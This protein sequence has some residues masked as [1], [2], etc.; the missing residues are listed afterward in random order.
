LDLGHPIET[1]HLCKDAEIPIGLITYSYYGN[2]VNQ[3]KSISDVHLEEVPLKRIEGPC[4]DLF[5]EIEDIRTS[6]VRFY[7]LRFYRRFDY[8]NNQIGY[9]ADGEHWRYPVNIEETLKG[10]E[11][12]IS[13]EEDFL[14]YINNNPISIKE[15]GKYEVENFDNIKSISFGEGVICECSY[16]TKI[17]TFNIEETDADIVIAKEKWKEKLEEY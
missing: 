5:K 14:V 1:I 10:I 17:K 8:F 2:T 16:Q 3:F 9:L 7:N 15:I 13:K 6:V 12:Y 4:E 11:P